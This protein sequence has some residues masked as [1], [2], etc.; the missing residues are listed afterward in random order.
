[1]FDVCFFD[2]LELLLTW[3]VAVES[4]GVEEIFIVLWFFEDIQGHFEGGVLELDD[5]IDEDLVFDLSNRE[6]F[7][8]SPELFGHPVRNNSHI[9]QVV[10]V[11]LDVW[12]LLGEQARQPE[13]SPWGSLLI[14][15]Y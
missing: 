3:L 11:A 10:N 1:M 8:Y 12:D 5:E 2:I 15:V 6:L 7:S 13:F 9:F 4:G 14:L